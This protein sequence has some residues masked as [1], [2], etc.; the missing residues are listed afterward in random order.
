MSV[1]TTY[2]LLHKGKVCKY[3]GG[4]SRRFGGVGTGKGVATK[5]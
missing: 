1:I 3:T 4:S 2:Q 5:F